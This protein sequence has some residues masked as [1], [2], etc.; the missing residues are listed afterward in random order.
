MAVNGCVSPTMTEAVGGEIAIET[1]V[2][3]GTTVIVTV[4]VVVPLTVPLV[5]VM[6][7]VPAATP[8]ARPPAMIVAV[9][10]ALEVQVAVAEMS[11]VDLSLLVAMA[12]NCWL[13][14]VG[15]DGSAGVTA[16]EVTVTVGGTTLAGG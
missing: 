15:T 3:G 1:S 13:P 9:A 12:V 4:N 5:A 10:G 8:V 2:A 7:V 16:I 14:F 11:F 6:V